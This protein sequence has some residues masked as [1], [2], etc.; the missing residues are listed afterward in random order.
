MRTRKLYTTLALISMISLLFLSCKAEKRDWEVANKDGSIQAYQKFIEKHPN[1]PFV[2]NATKKIEEIKE[3]VDWEEATQKNTIQKYQEFIKSH[4]ESVYVSEAKEK[5]RSRIVEELNLAFKSMDR[6]AF[7]AFLKADI[8]REFYR[9][10]PFALNNLAIFIIDWYGQNE[11][12]HNK[13]DK[14]LLQQSLALL[15][16][17]LT[18]A[19]GRMIRK[20]VT[21][22]VVRGKSGLAM[23]YWVE[24]A[25]KD[26]GEPLKAA[27]EHNIKVIEDM[28]A[29]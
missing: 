28:I 21:S 27:I 11:I 23:V 17:A 2:S 25:K 24:V 19:E 7:E 1:S 12:A 22:L 9:A 4:P 5:S 26:P 15:N 18:Q 3:K 20:E 13:D 6:G 8:V 14:E 29:K 10:D 16:S